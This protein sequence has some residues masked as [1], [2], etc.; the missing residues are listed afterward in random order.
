MVPE[1]IVSDL[2]ASLAFWCGLLGFGM[3]YARPE[4]RFAYLQ[5]GDA[6]IMLEE[7]EPSTRWLTGELENPFGRGINF[8]VAVDSCEPVLERLAEHGWPLFVEP[9]E[10]WYRAATVELGVRQ[11]LVQD[12]DGYLVRLQQALGARPHFSS[13]DRA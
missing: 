4:H 6:Q 3:A 1:L 11:F 5:L 2:E 13:D 9:E 10:R 12:P 8:Q 7:L